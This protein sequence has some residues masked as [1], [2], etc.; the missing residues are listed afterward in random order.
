MALAAVEESNPDELRADMQQYYGL[1][2]DGMGRDYSHA[3]AAVLMAQLP[4]SSRLARL[5]DPENEWSDETHFLS[6]I[7]YDLRVLAWQRS[8]DGQRGT[9]K[10]KPNKT[11]GDRAKAKARAK[12]FDKELVDKMLGGE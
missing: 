6:L 3:H 10:P 1:N 4:Q 12:G 8:K 5:S 2:I 7:E 11:P 9:N